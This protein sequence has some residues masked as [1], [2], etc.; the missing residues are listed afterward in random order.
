MDVAVLA[1]IK[2]CPREEVVLL[3]KFLLKALE[4]DAQGVLP[5]DVVHA[6]VVVDS[7]VRKHQAQLL[8]VDAEVLPLDVPLE[9]F[10]IRGD[11]LLLK[12]LYVRVGSGRLGLDL[13]LWLVAWICGTWEMASHRVLPHASPIGLRGSVISFSMSTPSDLP[14]LR[15]ILL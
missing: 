2:P 7:L 6:Q 4:V 8:R 9:V 5:G 15:W 11:E 1:R 13:E 14:R 10:W 3:R 12:L